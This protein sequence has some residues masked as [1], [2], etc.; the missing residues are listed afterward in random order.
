MTDVLA[1]DLIDDPQMAEQFEALAPGATPGSPEAAKAWNQLQGELDFDS[2]DGS[3]AGEYAGKSLDEGGGGRTA[4]LRDRIEVNGGTAEEAAG[5]AQGRFFK[6]VRM[7]AEGNPD[8][9]NASL[10]QRI[11]GWRDAHPV[12]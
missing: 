5:I 11:Q 9:A 10:G 4:L 6:V 12:G 7:W 1:V 8:M 3:P 2:S